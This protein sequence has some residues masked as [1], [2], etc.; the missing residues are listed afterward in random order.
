MT[1]AFGLPPHLALDLLGRRPDV[2]VARLRAE[3]AAKRM[4]VAQAAFYPNVNLTAF[5]GLLALDMSV[6]TRAGSQFGSVGPA[7][8]LPVFDAGRLKGNLKAA[9]AD[10]REAIANYD[11][12]VV[13]AMQDVAD[14]ATSQRALGG[15]IATAN[16]ATIAAGEAWRIQND[17]YRGG[18]ATYLDVLSAEETLLANERTLTD[19]SSRSLALDV[20]LVRALGG[21]YVDSSSS[22]ADPA[23]V[24]PALDPTLAAHGT[25]NGLR[26][27]P[28]SPIAATDQRRLR[29]F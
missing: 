2:A 24:G 17:R 12:T 4:D 9:E 23:R 26:L 20:A 5:I 8:S 13:Q 29:D 25:R 18:L 1:R 10:Y 3:A 22:H 11:K 15:Q 16:A 28:A 7:I 27:L 6:L 14:A 19:L 21:G